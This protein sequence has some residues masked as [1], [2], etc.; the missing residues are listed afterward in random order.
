MVEIHLGHGARTAQQEDAA[1]LGGAVQRSAQRLWIARHFNRRFNA[2]A[3]EGHGLHPLLVIRFR[4]VKGRV[5]AQSQRQR[6]PLRVHIADDD[7]IC[8][9]QPGILHREQPQQARTHHQTALSQTD[10]RLADG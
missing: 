7:G 4:R 2:F 1:K 5:R 6:P 8:A 9:G 10:F 3:R